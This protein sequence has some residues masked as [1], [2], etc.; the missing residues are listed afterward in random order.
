MTYEEVLKENEIDS[1]E[2]LKKILDNCVENDLLTI[3]FFAF[4]I[5][6]GLNDEFEKFNKEFRENIK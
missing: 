3:S 4:L 6:K 1:P 2:E 5:S